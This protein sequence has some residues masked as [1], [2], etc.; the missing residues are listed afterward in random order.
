M[1]VKR[2]KRSRMR[3]LLVGVMAV[4]VLTLPSAP[5]GGAFPGQNGKIVWFSTGGNVADTELWEMTPTGG[6][7][8]VIVDDDIY[9]GDPA[10]S[11]NGNRIVFTGDNKLWI[12]SMNGNN[13]EEIS[14]NQAEDPAWVG[15]DRIVFMRNGEL[16][17]I[18]AN[19]N[20][21][22]KFV[23]NQETEDNEEEPSWSPVTHRIAF[24]REFDTSDTE[25]FTVNPD[26]T[27]LK[28]LT[29]NDTYDDDPDWAPKSK[30]IAYTC[31]PGSLDN[32][33]CKMRASG[34]GKVNITNND[35]HDDE[36]PSWSPNGMFMV[37]ERH[38]DG[39]ADDDI[40]R[41]KANGDNQNDLTT[42]DYDDDNPDWQPL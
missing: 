22:P 4:G 8:Q 6:N 7:Q 28:R 37:Y 26:G 38:T 11:P 39:D 2:L 24:A 27:K 31:R 13:I 19:G 16:M 20:G 14:P 15:N 21:L 25:I 12:M 35:G 5:A 41:M 30:M 17:I 34:K 36:E 3:L 1:P 42:N 32:D 40:W 29:N 18:N 10:V 33:V 9:N 23:L